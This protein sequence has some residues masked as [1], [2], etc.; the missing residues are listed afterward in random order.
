MNTVVCGKLIFSI[1]D[2]YAVSKHVFTKCVTVVKT[3]I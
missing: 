1:I 2:K 3:I